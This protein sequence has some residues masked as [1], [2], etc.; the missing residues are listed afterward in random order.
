[1][2]RRI[3]IA[4]ALAL[5]ATA[6]QSLPVSSQASSG[7]VLDRV[8]AVVNN[9]AILSSDLDEEMRLA[10]LEPGDG[11]GEITPAVA[12]DHLISRAL[13]Q[14]QMRQE[15][16]LRAEP[17]P[18]VVAA[19]LSQLRADLPACVRAKCSTAEGWQ[20]F[21][22]AHRLDEDRVERYLANRLQILSFLEQRFRTGM[23]VSREDIEAYYRT[24][25]LPQYPAG[26]KP[27]P[28]DAVAPR[29]EE[30]LLQ[31]RVSALVGDWLTSL[32]R[33]GEIEI[34]DPALESAEMKS[35]GGEGQE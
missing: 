34:L 31:Q 35:R 19:R 8:V 13:I 29:I 33:Q 24:S 7:V 10:V 15:E 11:S 3:A 20:A 21:L 22:A 30:I 12:L 17:A 23:R 14:Q 16:I 1:M 28:L 2:S 26:E 5:A 6:G 4:A 32:R 18:A 9:Q 27:P 25:L